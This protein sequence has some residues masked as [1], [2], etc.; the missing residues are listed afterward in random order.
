MNC[1]LSNGTY[2]GISS[3]GPPLGFSCVHSFSDGGKKCTSNVDCL[4]NCLITKDTILEKTDNMFSPKVV[5]GFGK[6]EY[7]DKPEPCYPGN[8]EYTFAFCI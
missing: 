7:G 4:G 3:P 1:I 6:C 2:E 8:F 5:G